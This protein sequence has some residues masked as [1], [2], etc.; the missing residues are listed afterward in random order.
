M[1]TEEHN[2]KQFPENLGAWDE[3]PPPEL[4]S[5]VEAM[6][7]APP[8]K[9]KV[10]K[11]RPGWWAGGLLLLLIPA[12]YFWLKSPEQP[13]MLSMVTPNPVDTL[14]GNPLPHT[15]PL[16]SAD[17]APDLSPDANNPAPSV[18]PTPDRR[19]IDQP[20]VL[21]DI[22]SLSVGNLFTND[23][24]YFSQDATQADSAG[25]MTRQDSLLF[26]VNAPFPDINAPQQ[27]ANRAFNSVYSNG[28]WNDQQAPI[29]QNYQN[30]MSYSAR[31][32]F[33]PSTTT[34]I[35]ELNWLLGS[36]KRMGP[37]GSAYE[38]WKRVDKY[39]LTGRGYFVINGDT[40][41]TDRMQ[42]REMPDGLY[43]IVA[44]DTNRQAHKYRLRHT[45]PGKAVFQ[46]ETEQNEYRIE[47]RA[48]NDQE[49]NVTRNRHH[50]PGLGTETQKMSREGPGIDDYAEPPTKGGKFKKGN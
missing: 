14:D 20:P 15:V 11:F 43:Y 27:V 48:P 39:T 17:L 32:A 5:Q 1:A 22:Q 25:G 9:G 3:S 10:R 35:S 41:V 37:S 42:I 47:F 44:V 24:P 31:S 33:N 23:P 36:W 30:Q 4:W 46:T 45:G 21:L 2:W 38:E 12:A 16:P 34:T 13:A 50:G 49:L 18:G 29:L 8:P 19:T 6:M 26:Y 28:N 40:T 7:D